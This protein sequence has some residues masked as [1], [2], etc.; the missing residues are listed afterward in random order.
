M[1]ETMNETIEIPVTKTKR[2]R[3]KDINFRK[4][5]F[6]AHLA[7][8]MF[9]ADYENGEWQDAKILPYGNLSFSPAI[10]ALHYGQSVFEGM[11]AFRMSDGRISVFRIE[12]HLDR[13]NK[14][15]ERMCM[16][17]I[18]EELFVSAIHKLVEVDRQWVPKEEDSSLYIRPLVFA[19]EE[20]LGVKVS[21]RYKFMVLTSPVGP[22]YPKPL[23]V[24]VETEFVRAAEGGTGYAKCAGNYGGSFYASSR[25]RK[26]GFDQ[27]LWTDS[28]EHKYFDEAGTMNLFFLLD[29]ILVTPPL[30]TT[31]LDGVTRAS[32]LDIARDLNLPA[33][34]RR[35]TIAEVKEAL[36]KGTLSEAFGTGTAAVVAPIKTI[37]ISGKDY[38]LPDCDE[39]CFM[40]R[41]KKQLS[42]I[43]HGRQPDIH[44]WNY[45][46]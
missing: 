12:K 39:S 26:E 17:Q 19:T 4:L 20:R 28:K 18:P 33:E 10:L 44:G 35:V 14:S 13:L 5:E 42:D 16:P 29:G 3:L 34:E 7:D 32:I 43:R 2:S 30:S 45:I 21:D 15:L 23:R 38:N 25:A 24:K 1:F 40:L 41:A 6:G 27:V 36:K 11:K 22:Y 8:H 31:I 37:S 9:S 46:I